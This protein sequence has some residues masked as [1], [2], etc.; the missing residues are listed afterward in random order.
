MLTA[1]SRKYDEL[2]VGVDSTTVVVDFE[3]AAIIA[4]RTVLGQHVVIQ[5]CFYHLTQSTWRHIQ[6][7][8][9]VPLYNKNEN[10]KQFCRMLDALAFLPVVE[11]PAGMGYLRDNILECEGNDKLE[12]LLNYFDRTYVSG[13]LRSYNVQTPADPCLLFISFVFHPSIHLTC[14]MITTLQFPHS[15][16]EQF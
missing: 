12:Q 15:T 9:L 16:Y 5:L 7:T 14:G 10:V 8:T 13:S 2:H 1:V 11:V 6:D 4:V 3:Q